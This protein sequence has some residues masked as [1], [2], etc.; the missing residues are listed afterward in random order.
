[1]VKIQKLNEMITTGSPV[2]L[3]ADDSQG[4]CTCSIAAHVPPNCKAVHLYLSRASGTGT[5]NLYPLSGST[6]I[7]GGH[8]GHVL[9]PISGRNI[10][11]SCSAAEVWT[12]KAVG[13]VVEGERKTR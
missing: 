2:T 9:L 5:I 12:L 7:V 6:A 11:Y 1:M 3:F 4:V 8:Q 10:K 13:Y